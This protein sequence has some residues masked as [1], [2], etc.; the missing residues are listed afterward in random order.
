MEKEKRILLLHSSALRPL[1]RERE[2]ER[3]K[4]ARAREREREREES[5][6]APSVFAFCL[7]LVYISAFYEERKRYTHLSNF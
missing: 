2:R 5:A 4:N 1:T 3:R 7:S 6:I